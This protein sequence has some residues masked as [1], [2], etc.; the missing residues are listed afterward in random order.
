MGRDCVS[1]LSSAQAEAC[2]DSQ[3]VWAAPDPP[4]SRASRAA[5]LEAGSVLR[6]SASSSSSSSSST[7]W[8]HRPDPLPHEQ[9]DR[10]AVC[11]WRAAGKKIYLPDVLYQSSLPT[12]LSRGENTACG[13]A[14]RTSPSPFIFWDTRTLQQL[15]VSRL[16]SLM[17]HNKENSRNMWYHLALMYL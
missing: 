16:S 7:T 1:E 8:T 3:W 17:K 10:Q 15:K 5:I 14:N 6:C 11:H 4:L 2:T 9:A 13:R 12:R